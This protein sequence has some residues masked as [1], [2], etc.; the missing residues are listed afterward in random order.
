MHLRI[1]ICGITREA[2]AHHAS[3]LGADA[4]GLNFSTQSPRYV[5]PARAHSLLRVLPPFVDAVGLFVNQP[6]HQVYTL[7]NALG[8]I[9]TIQWH[10]DQVEMADTF[11]FRFI[12]AFPVRDASSLQT[13][14]RYL[15]TCRLMNRMPS[16]IL[17]DAHVAGRYGGT[18]KTAPW[19]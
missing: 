12:P 18:G 4:I 15:D 16:A 14:T 3:Y 5:D 10:G 11:P 6:L 7:L 9:Y 8:G 19:D 17:V 2:D 1:K 13:I